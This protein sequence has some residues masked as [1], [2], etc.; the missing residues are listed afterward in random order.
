MKTILKSIAAAAILA[1]AGS[2]SAAVI[3]VGASNLPESNYLSQGSY[4]GLFNLNGLSTL[5]A[6]FS[7]NSLSFSFTFADDATDLFTDV[8]GTSSTTTSTTVTGNG[9]N[10]IATTTTTVST[11]VARTGERESVQLSFGS[12]NFSGQTLAGLPVMGTPVIVPEEARLAG[13]VKVKDGMVC[14]QQQLN[15]GN[16][17]KSVNLYTVAQT[18]TTTTT[19]DYSGAFTLDGT[20][21]ASLLQN[22]ML[23]FN[24]GV[25][26]D[27]LLSNASLTVDYTETPSEV[28]EPGSLALFGLAL[29]GVFGVRSKRRA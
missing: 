15:Q 16:S 9:N 28:P 7:V 4:Q 23:G 13:T 25:T 29:A 14:T 6:K 24:L 22:N 12:V 10:Q 27:L 20:L 17:C 1:T 26:G 11:P 18:S 3:T 2:A 19:T 8:A 21:L 5:P